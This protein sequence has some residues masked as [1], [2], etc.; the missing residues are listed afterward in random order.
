MRNLR[1]LFSYLPATRRQMLELKLILINTKELI[2]ATQ[3]EIAAGLTAASAALTKIGQETTTTLDKVR[4]LEEQINNGNVSP[5]L[6]AAFDDLKA[7]V[8]R[9]DDMVPD[10][11]PTPENPMPEA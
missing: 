11:I 4:A 6:Q 10:A 8:Q 9:V 5:E 2:M 1:P 7:Q 3:A